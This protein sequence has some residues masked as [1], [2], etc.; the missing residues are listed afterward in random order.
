MLY[1]SPRPLPSQ[2]TRP[3]RRSNRR[4]QSA[5]HILLSKMESV[6]QR[7][8]KKRAEIITSLRAARFHSSSSWNASKKLH[9]PQI[10]HCQ[11]RHQLADSSVYS[12][13]VPLRSPSGV[14]WGPSC[15]PLGEADSRS[16]CMTCA[17]AISCSICAASRFRRACS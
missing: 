5:P 2:H 16:F 1:Y 13:G 3:K 11:I 9:I 8:H 15:S 14:G 17:L 10:C 12:R 4:I 7:R 6:S